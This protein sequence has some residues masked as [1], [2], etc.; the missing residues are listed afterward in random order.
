MASQTGPKM[1]S[2]RKSFVGL[3]RIINV[4]RWFGQTY[5]GGN[6]PN[7]MPF[8][9]RKKVAFI[10]YDIFTMVLVFVCMPTLAEN[11]QT[12]LSEKLAEKMI[13]NAINWMTNVASIG[14]FY[15]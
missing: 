11:M 15:I 14:Q 7:E 8:S 1:L 2:K 10:L 3:Q 4:H 9:R 6:L 5:G 13:M 12:S